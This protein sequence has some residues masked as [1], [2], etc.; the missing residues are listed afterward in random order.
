MAAHIMKRTLNKPVWLGSQEGNAE[1]APLEAVHSLFGKTPPRLHSSASSIHRPITV[2][3]LFHK[4]FSTLGQ[5]KTICHKQNKTRDPEQEP[6]L[7]E[8]PGVMTVQGRHA[9][10]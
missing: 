3:G 7:G 10:G 6:P 8:G 2:W 4:Y 9:Q 1:R 5:L